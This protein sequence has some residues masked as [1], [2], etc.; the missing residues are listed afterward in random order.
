LA[1]SNPPRIPE[2]LDESRLEGVFAVDRELGPP[3]S[4]ILLADNDLSEASRNIE[5]LCQLW[6][7][8][9]N[10]LLPLRNGRTKLTEPWSTF[11]RHAEIEWVRGGGLLPERSRLNGHYVAGGG[12]NGDPILKVL[13]AI[14]KRPDE[15]RPVRVSVVDKDDPWFV[16]YLGTL[17]GWPS[18]PEPEH[19][20]NMRWRP[21]VEFDAFVSTRFEDVQ[22]AGHQDLLDRLRNPEFFIPTAISRIELACA[23]AMR[24]MSLTDVHPT[25]PKD[26]DLARNV[27][28]NIVVVYEPGSIDDLCLLWDLRAAHGLPYGFPLAI[29][30]TVE[31]EKALDS[32]VHGYAATLWQVRRLRPVV[33][34]L[35][36]GRVKLRSICRAATLDWQVAD[37][38]EILQDISPPGRPSTDV[39]TFVDG[40]SRVSAWSDDD[41]RLL[42]TRGPN[43]FFRA[44]VRFRP[45]S[46]VLPRSLELEKHSG[47]FS[48]PRGGWWETGASKPDDVAKCEWPAGWTVLASVAKDRG[49]RAEP[50]TAGKSA[51]ALLHRLGSLD[52]LGAM[53]SDVLLGKLQTLCEREG[54]SWFREQ[55]RQV[56]SKAAE[57]ED[58]A[59][60][61]LEEIRA[62]HVPQE[63]SEAPHTLTFSQLRNDVFRDRDLTVAWLA[64]A[65]RSGLLVRGVNVSC[66]RCDAKS[67]RAVG[68]ISPPVVCRGCGLNIDSPFPADRLEFRYRASEVL[69]RATTHDTLS[70]LLAM[71]YFCELYRPVDNNP[72]ALYGA[73]PG[74]DFYDL[75]TDDRVGEA[76]VVLVF[77]TGELVV[78]ECKRFGRGLTLDEIAKL[79]KV[80]ESLGSEWTFVSTPSWSVD[81]PQIW[82][83]CARSLPDRPRFSLTGEHLF[84]VDVRQSVDENALAGVESSEATRQEMRRQFLEHCK[85]LLKWLAG[86]RGWE[87]WH[88]RL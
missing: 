44:N 13:A 70:H 69:V 65:E 22:N 40:Q 37:A 51:V 68:E 82:S 48:G 39:V 3:I 14:G 42:T 35:S 20:K 29:P 67:W 11:L 54:M 47:T 15:H 81:C 88:S 30:V 59:G 49:M 41:R 50:S 26:A 46:L 19:L 33:V 5:R 62:L 86:P 27:G 4:A 6:G 34:S 74:V 84:R 56:T 38:R 64:W 23:Q 55:L 25:F 63:S 72:S 21:D 17:G 61:L 71:R 2:L 1:T 79:D 8:A 24:N 77:S 76:D 10:P 66:N 85:A 87:A 78:G 58:Q 75:K 45:Q 12:P 32:W 28:P 60:A 36:V 52:D 7:G 18:R 43:D 83:E 16:S 9:L 73:Y 80:A 53:L 31:V 57:D